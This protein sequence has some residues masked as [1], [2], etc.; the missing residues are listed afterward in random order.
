[1]PVTLI[2]INF[3][4]I[5]VVFILLLIAVTSRKKG[6]LGKNAKGKCIII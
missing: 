6:Q 3:N 4:S 1:M 2:C 5:L